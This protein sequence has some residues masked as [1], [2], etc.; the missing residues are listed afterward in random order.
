[1]GTVARGIMLRSDYRQYPSYPHGYA[2]HLTLGFIASSLGALAVPAILEKQYTAVTFLVLA[3]QQFR[4]IR[5]ME[6]D[7]LHDLE[8][9]ELVPRGET[10][11]D[12]IAKVF[13]ARNYL[14]MLTALVT[15]IVVEVFPRRWGLVGVG[16]GVLSGFAVM[17][18][19]T[20]LRIEKLF[21]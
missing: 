14:A 20:L 4:D 13:E 18:M 15:A 1:M 19:L 7:S 3:A 6:H 16:A 21:Q 11:I 17:G 5:K 10:Y 9:G 2:I 12:G 8:A